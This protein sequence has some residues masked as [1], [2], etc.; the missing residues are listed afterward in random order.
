MI[1]VINTNS[2]QVTSHQC[3][4]SCAYYVRGQTVLVGCDICHSVT[5]NLQLPQTWGIKMSGRISLISH[6]F[7]QNVRLEFMDSS[8][9]IEFV[10]L[11]QKQKK[12]LRDMT[13][14]PNPAANS[15]ARQVPSPQSH[16]L[17]ATKMFKFEIMKYGYRKTNSRE[18]NDPRCAEQ[19]FKVKICK[20][21]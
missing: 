14:L 7:V 15:G 13:L 21:R 1:P 17:L 10:S 18:V 2:T 11:V 16:L 4:V 5:G 19:K 12:N 8:K 20:T 6:C 9:C 3:A